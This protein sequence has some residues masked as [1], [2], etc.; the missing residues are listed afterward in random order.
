MRAS[1]P[2]IAAR[3]RLEQTQRTLEAAERKA[4]SAEADRAEKGKPYED[5]PLFIYLFRRGFGTSAYR[6][7]SLARFFDGKVARFIGY[8]AAR[9]NYQLLNEIPPRLREHAERQ[10]QLLAQAREQLAGVEKAGLEAA[11]LGPLIDEARRAQAGLADT[12]RRL[13]G[14]DAV[15][16]KLDAEQDKALAARAQEAEA[17]AVRLVADADSRA[18]VAELY[19]KAAMTMSAADDA[20]VRRIEA[21]D[22]T[23]AAAERA[24]LELVGRARALARRRHEIEAQ[25]AG[26]R[27]RGYDNP[28]GR[29]SNEGAIADAL[30]GFLKGAITGAVLG[31]VFQQGY[32]ERDRRA[33]S[34]FGGGGGFNFPGAGERWP[35]PGGFDGWAGPGAGPPAD[36][37]PWGGGDG[38]R[39]GGGF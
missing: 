38:F 22:K 2:W 32:Q 20:L 17:E 18:S 33:D 29:F 34:S 3:E 39:T 28:M 24:H 1:G 26:F 27:R 12:D 37:G 5:D 16:A 7:G 11:G 9:A 10:K 35:D 8:D 14:A 23:L 36:Q 4:A 13:S 19:R 30:G 6:A 31:Q 25:R 15:L 21:G